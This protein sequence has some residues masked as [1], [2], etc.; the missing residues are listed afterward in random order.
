M[1]RKKR[2]QIVFKCGR[3]FLFGL[4]PKHKELTVAIVNKHLKNRSSTFTTVNSANKILIS[5]LSDRSMMKNV[6]NFA[7]KEKSL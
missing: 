3:E 7:E 1:D 4:V 5:S 2:M 6:I